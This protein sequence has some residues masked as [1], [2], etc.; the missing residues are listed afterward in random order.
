MCAQHEPPGPDPDASFDSFD[1]DRL[2][3]A[4]LAAMETGLVPHEL[5]KELLRRLWSY[6]AL[7]QA[8]AEPEPSP[9]ARFTRWLKVSAEVPLAVALAQRLADELDGPDLAT[10]RTEVVD[11][12]RQALLAVELDWLLGS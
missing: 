7:L 9:P 6:L 11:A 1:L 2:T 12:L 10:L 3:V 5:V 8:A 4:T